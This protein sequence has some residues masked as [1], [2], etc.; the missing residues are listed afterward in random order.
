MLVRPFSSSSSSSKVRTTFSAFSVSF[1]WLPFVRESRLQLL[2][3]LS[4]QH[5]ISGLHEPI[6]RTSASSRR[7]CCHSFPIAVPGPWCRLSSLVRAGTCIR[8]D[9]SAPKLHHQG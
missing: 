4:H 9:H 8:Q 1:I 6:A 7:G 5:L 3:L 2:V